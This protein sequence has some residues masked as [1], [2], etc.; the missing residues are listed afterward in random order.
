MSKST[1][2]QHEL[3]AFTEYFNSFYGPEGIYSSTRAISQSEI[4]AAL[5]KINW[6]WGG[7]DSVDRENTRDLIFTNEEMDVMYS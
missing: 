4:E 3:E 1:I 5:E 7:G 2:P 6:E